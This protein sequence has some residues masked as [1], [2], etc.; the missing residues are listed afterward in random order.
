MK[1]KSKNPFEFLK[2]RTLEKAAPDIQDHW[3]NAEK[4]RSVS[5]HQIK[6]L[7]QMKSYKEHLNSVQKAVAKAHDKALD[8]RIQNIGNRLKH[9]K[10]QA[11]SHF[12][13]V[14]GG[15]DT[16]PMPN[17]DYPDNYPKNDWNPNAPD[18][19]AQ[20]DKKSKEDTQ[21]SGGQSKH[22]PED[23]LTTPAPEMDYKPSWAAS[24]DK[25]VARNKA[26][27]RSKR[28]NREKAEASKEKDRDRD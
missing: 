12:S 14:K 27:Q 3:K 22:L 10:G 24:V 21:K 8:D 15:P 11:V 4:D 19:K 23:K 16:M 26:I 20:F 2:Q 5:R 1:D 9:P 25:Q 6:E 13:K 7:E 18:M 17:N 28:I